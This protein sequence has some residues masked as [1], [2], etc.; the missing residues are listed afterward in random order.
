MLTAE[1]LVFIEAQSTSAPSSLLRLHAN[2]VR[3]A[4]ASLTGELRCH[5]AALLLKLEHLD[6]QSRAELACPLMPAYLAPCLTLGASLQVA[7]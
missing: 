6:H 2:E 7:A 5:A 3:S 1:Q 4:L